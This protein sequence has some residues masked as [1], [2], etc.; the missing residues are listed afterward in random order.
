MAMKSDAAIP[1]AERGM[2][3]PRFGR[4][5][6]IV[7]DRVEVV[8]DDGAAGMETGDPP[9]GGGAVDTNQAGGG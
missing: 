9:E 1:E 3:R 6:R 5:G 4:G 7:L 8:E 2:W